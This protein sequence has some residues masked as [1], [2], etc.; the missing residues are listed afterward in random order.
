MLP[1]GTH[2]ELPRSAPIG[3]MQDPPGADFGALRLGELGTCD[4]VLHNVGQVSA[5]T[6]RAT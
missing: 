4:I 2:T 1:D 3:G 6:V 5:A